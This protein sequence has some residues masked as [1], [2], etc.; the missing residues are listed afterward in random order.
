MISEIRI[1][2]LG[3]I[4]AAEVPLGERFTVLT[5]ETGA[6][7]TMVLTALSML[8]GARPPTGLVRGDRARVE[9]RWRLSNDVDGLASVVADAGG[10]FDGDE[11]LLA[12]VVPADGRAR[13]FVGGAGVPAAVLAE[14]ASELVAVHGQSDQLR[15]RQPARQRALL[16]AYAGEALHA[17]AHHYRQL[18]AEHAAVTAELT[19]RTEGAVARRSEA[20]LL[21]HGLAAIDAVDPQPGEDEALRAEAERLANVE[22]LALACA[23]AHAAVSDDDGGE[24]ALSRIAAAARQ[25]ERA[26]AHDAELASL[27][28]RF[29]ECAELLADAAADLSGYA[30]SLDADPGRLAW[31]HQRRADLA[32]LTRTYGPTVDDVLAW[33]ATAGPRLAD[34]EGDDGRVEELT[35]AR[36]ALR[37]ELAE[38]AE[39][40]SR[41]RQRAAATLAERVSEELTGLAM[42]DAE[43]SITLTRQPDPQ[44]LDVADE[45]VAFTA[46]GVD[47]VQFLLAPHRGAT[48]APLGAGASGGELSRVMLALEVALA[49]VDAVGTMIFDEVDAGVGGRAAVEIGRRLARLAEHTQVIV[50]THLPQVAA[51]ADTHLVVSKDS[52]GAVTASDVLVVTGQAR[53][54]ELARMLAG[55]EDS[56]HALAHADELLELGRTEAQRAHRR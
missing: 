13:A 42:P 16:D 20:E 27:A 32:R 50:V 49:G 18:F 24:D 7:K 30:E 35:A 51:F 48:P 28:A 33:A 54:R 3:V 56:S 19:E 52:A 47:Q 23:S 5:G 1:S 43:L 4:D 12:R 44:G 34:L 11:L 53:R 6:G 36:A 45:T 25:L 14:V 29:H 37:V 9:G 46:D 41:V 55:H 17:L 15:L 22:D 31:V 39:A 40:M 10:E 21:A 26:G 38:A 2:G 8:M